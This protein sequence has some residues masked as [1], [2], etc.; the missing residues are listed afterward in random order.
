MT[1]SVIKTKKN[2]AHILRWAGISSL[3]ETIK[4]KE[5]NAGEGDLNKRQTCSLWLL[6]VEF[7]ERREGRH[8]LS[9]KKKEFVVLLLCSC[10][11]HRC[12]AVLLLYVVAV[13]CSH[14]LCWALL[15][16]Q[17][18][19]ISPLPLFLLGFPLFLFLE[20][21]NWEWLPKDG[22]LLFFTVF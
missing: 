3:G 5:Q 8:C 22:I 16:A 17:H 12:C 11:C 15:L 1:P 6:V 19:F 7:G 21:G 13:C 4:K 10:C 2:S 20:Y 9:K 14:M 18:L